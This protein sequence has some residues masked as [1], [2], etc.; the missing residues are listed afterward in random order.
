MALVSILI[1]VPSTP[2]PTSEDFGDVSPTAASI[3]L[4]LTKLWWHKPYQSG[5]KNDCIWAWIR[6]WSGIAFALSG[7]GWFIG[8][9]PW[10]SLG[11]SSRKPAVPS[12]YGQFN[13]CCDNLSNVNYIGTLIWKHFL[14]FLNW[15]DQLKR[16]KKEEIATTWNDNN[17]DVV[18]TK[19]IPFWS[20]LRMRHCS[21]FRQHKL[22]LWL[23]LRYGEART[24]GGDRP[25]QFTEMGC[26]RWLIVSE[27]SPFSVRSLSR[28]GLSDQ[29]RQ[30]SSSSR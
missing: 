27:S 20:T 14:L 17:Q 11:G 25:R 2:N 3:F 30:P 15:W 6:R 7:W 22:T 28:D 10:S 21:K 13:A 9:A 19:W 18:L 1:V 12:S 5:A 8:D 23:P 16:S 26:E 4:Q 29:S 24:G